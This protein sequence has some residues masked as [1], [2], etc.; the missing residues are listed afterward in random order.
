MFQFSSLFLERV[1]LVQGLKEMLYTNE[2]QAIKPHLINAGLIFLPLFIIQ[3][4]MLK[5]SQYWFNKHEENNESDK[6]VHQKYLERKVLINKIFNFF[7]T[8]ITITYLFN[9]FANR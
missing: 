2:I 3:Y 1:N 7:Y 4:A 9:L 8:V 5:Y 6:S